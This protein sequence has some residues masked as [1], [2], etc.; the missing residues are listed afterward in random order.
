MRGLGIAAAVLI[1]LYVVADLALAVVAWGTED[2]IAAYRAGDATSAAPFEQATTF[3]DVVDWLSIAT[4]VGSAVLFL[5]WLWRAR[6]NA[7]LL[8]RAPH[9]RSRVW[10][11][12][13]WFVPVVALWF[14]LQV[15][16][17]VW[18]ASHPDADPEGYNMYGMSSTN[19]LGWWWAAWLVDLVVDQYITRAT[20]DDPLDPLIGANVLSF[21]VSAIAGVLV[22]RLI[23]HSSW[24]ETK[25]SQPQLVAAH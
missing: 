14:P 13:G 3:I 9:T 23:M 6:V 12:A 2:V 20:L 22:V 16:R 5:L 1:G 8:C 11:W 21:V 18:K 10:V 15:V 17:D 24:Q 7:E 19:V 4:L 25:M